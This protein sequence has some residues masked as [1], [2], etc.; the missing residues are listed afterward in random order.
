VRQNWTEG[1]AAIDRRRAIVGEIKHLTIGVL[2]RDGLPHLE[3]C[4]ASLPAL[5]DC[6]VSVEFILVDSASTD[7][8]L[9]AMRAFADHRNAR[10]FSMTGNVN[11]SVTRNLILDHARDG[12]L[13]L[14]D[15]DVAV[16]RDFVIAA[17]AEIASGHADIVCGQLPEIWHT[18]DHEPYADSADRYQVSRRRY[19]HYFM[20][21]VMLGPRVL[22]DGCRY[23]PEMRR[24]EDVEFSI[25][26]S[27]R[28]R[29]LTLPVPIGTHYT[30]PY[31]S[32][33]RIG[34]FYKDAYLKPAGRFVR[35]NWRRPWRLWWSRSIFVG[36]ATGLAEQLGL[37]LALWSGSAAAVA[38]VG[39]VIACD[40][41]RFAIKGRLHQ[42]V[43]IR[44]RGPWQIL[45]GVFTE[46][47][48]PLDYRATEVSR[49][50]RAA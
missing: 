22:A 19:T 35:I 36:H 39:A 9:D 24:F 26:I 3:R 17:L 11:Q 10:V 45:S 41:A 13:L 16:S 50:P 4:L 7:R 2:S 6:A 32:T 28:F 25:R 29:I 44:V 38:L 30:I 15:G 42:F 47:P 49:E 23:D 31:H 20:G 27:E 5:A 48:A 37:L 21:N 14:V 12:A 18:S 8:T 43:P 33:Y 34:S 1:G 46:R 40:I